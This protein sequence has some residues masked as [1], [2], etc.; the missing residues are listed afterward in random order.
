[1]GNLGEK[2]STDKKKNIPKIIPE[3]IIAGKCGGFLLES[4]QEVDEIMTS[5]GM[6]HVSLDTP[7]LLRYE[8]D[9]LQVTRS[10]SLSRNDLSSLELIRKW[11]G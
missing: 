6:Q 10:P 7:P 2:K 9:F 11:M 8:G 4:L 1:M 3:G 5:K